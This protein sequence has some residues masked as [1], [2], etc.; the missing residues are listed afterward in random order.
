MLPVYRH[1]GSTL[2]DE[3]FSRYPDAAMDLRQ[4][5][6]DLV[7]E[8]FLLELS[9]GRMGHYPRY[10]E[11]MEERLLALRENP[12]RDHQRMNQVMPWWSRYLERLE[13]GAIYDEAMDEFRWLIEEYRVSVF[14]QRLGTAVKVSEKR[15][16]TAWQKVLA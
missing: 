2:D 15:L 1:L 13:E 16:A 3:F 10:L 12:T 6:D 8:G 7:Y 11:A 9:P 5:L 14:A 4:Q